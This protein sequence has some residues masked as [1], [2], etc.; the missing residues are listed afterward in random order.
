M[1]ESPLKQPNS[2]RKSIEASKQTVDDDI[3]MTIPTEPD[4][5]LDKQEALH[6]S[7]GKQVTG[8]LFRLNSKKKESSKRKKTEVS[9][10]LGVNN[11]MLLQGE[12][13]EL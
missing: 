8:K 6:S 1:S 2:T 13:E 4:K 11:L 5:D 10:T 3:G 7:P 12:Q 9:A